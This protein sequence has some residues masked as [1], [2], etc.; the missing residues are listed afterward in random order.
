M[1]RLDRGKVGGELLDRLGAHPRSQPTSSGEIAA[2]SQG[3]F[4]SFVAEAAPDR[5]DQNVDICS[6]EHRLKLDDHLV[7]SLGVERRQ[8]S[9]INACLDGRQSKI[10]QGC[11]PRLLTLSGILKAGCRRLELS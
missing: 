1:D 4:I 2:R 10:P 8:P 9:Q 11:P 6:G 5:F 3:M 7:R